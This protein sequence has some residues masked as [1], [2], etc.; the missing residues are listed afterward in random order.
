MRI[1]KKLTRTRCEQILISVQILQNEFTA[2]TKCAVVF[3]A[4]QF[5]TTL[6]YISQFEKMR[7][8]SVLC[9]QPSRLPIERLG[10]H[11]GI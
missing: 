10:G 2:A 11:V 3:Y 6:Q 5:V 9:I 8:R 1:A 7:G 4:P